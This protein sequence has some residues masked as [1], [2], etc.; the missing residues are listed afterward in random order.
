MAIGV[1]CNLDAAMTK[2][3]AYIAYIVAT[4]KP[5]RGICMS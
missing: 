5:D 2:L 3:I 1:I 4:E